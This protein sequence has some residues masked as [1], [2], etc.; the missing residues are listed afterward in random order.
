MSKKTSGSIIGGR[1][2]SFYDQG[3]RAYRSGYGYRPCA[4]RDWKAG[5]KAAIHEDI[6]WANQ[7]YKPSLVAKIQ[8]RVCKALGVEAGKG[9]HTVTYGELV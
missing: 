2:V 6:A 8:A 7:C 5:W 3:H 1:W 4:S 9:L